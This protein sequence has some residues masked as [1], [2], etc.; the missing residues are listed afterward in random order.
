MD[1]FWILRP[2]FALLTGIALFIGMAGAG[3]AADSDQLMESWQGFYAGLNA[4]WGRNGDDV[5]PYCVNS[6]GVLNGPVCQAVPAASISG[7]GFIG[8]GQ[9]GYNLQFKDL[10][11]GIEADLE[12]ADISGSR[13]MNGPFGYVGAGLALPAAQFTAEERLEWLGTVRLRL[14]YAVGAGTL[15]Y[16]TGGLAVGRFELTSN[17]TSPA[18][19]LF[20]VNE[21]VTKYGWTVGGGVEQ[22]LWSQ[23]SV[24]LEALYYDLGNESTN[25]I[26]PGACGAGIDGYARGAQFDLRGVVVRAGANWAFGE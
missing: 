22:A 19:F 1:L 9:V 25:G 3:Q 16:A 17:F 20:P 12:G 13:T 11:V 7:S 8:G 4:G 5:T 23:T 26:C 15:V 14:G 10:V 21:R 2:L 18:P 6:A 24:K